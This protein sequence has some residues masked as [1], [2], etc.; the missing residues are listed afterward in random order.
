MRVHQ[1]APC[2]A[3]EVN[4]RNVE[5]ERE[6][7]VIAT[8]EKEEIARMAKTIAALK[9]SPKRIGLLSRVGK[10]SFVGRQKSSRKL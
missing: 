9:L 3:R 8:L 1:G 7:D 10:A 6:M 4:D 5:G 2:A